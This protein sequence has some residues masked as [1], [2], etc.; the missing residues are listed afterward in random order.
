MTIMSSIF[1][2]KYF[3]SIPYLFFYFFFKANVPEMRRT[4]IEIILLPK[5]MS[6][7]AVK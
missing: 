6:V 4:Q 5:V 1:K 2:V 7:R 3:F